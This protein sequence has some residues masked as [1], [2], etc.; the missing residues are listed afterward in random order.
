VVTSSQ[1]THYLRKQRDCSGYQVI[2]ISETHILGLNLP[3][4]RVVLAATKELH[5]TVRNLRSRIRALEAA[6]NKLHLDR[7]GHSHPML[8]PTQMNLDAIEDLPRDVDTKDKSNPMQEIAFVRGRDGASRIAAAHGGIWVAHVGVILPNRSKLVL[9]HAGSP[10]AHTLS[11]DQQLSA[12]WLTRGNIIPES[13]CDGSRSRQ[14]CLF[15]TVLSLDY[16]GKY[17]LQTSW[18]PY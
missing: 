4:F 5:N 8:S 11:L 12:Q 9:D 6:L 1:L 10:L 14:L 3:F 18:K 17:R 16:S 13:K 7:T 15:L 2:S